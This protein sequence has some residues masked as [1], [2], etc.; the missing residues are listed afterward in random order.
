V[1]QLALIC[2]FDNAEKLT[3]HTVSHGSISKMA[4]RGVAS[5]EILGHPRHKSVCIN[6]VYQSHNTAA[7]DHRNSF[8]MI[9]RKK[10]TGI[11][12]TEMNSSFQKYQ[13]H[14]VIFLVLYHTTFP[15]VQYHA[16]VRYHTQSICTNLGTVTG[17]NPTHMHPNSCGATNYED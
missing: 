16:P 14:H 12:S 3:G 1:H 10:S 5:S 11:N 4:I 7:S 6:T 2:K 9:G 17:N 13:Y 15:M 8:F